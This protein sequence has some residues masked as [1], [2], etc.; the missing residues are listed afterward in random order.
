MQWGAGTP[1]LSR[2]P[3]VVIGHQH[4]PSPLE[5]ML[6]RAQYVGSPSITI[7][8][9]GTYVASHD[10]FGWGSSEKTSGITKIYRSNVR[11]ESWTQTAMLEGQFWSTVFA[12]DD[13]LY[14]IG[15]ARKSG[16]LIIRKSADA[17]ATWTEPVDEQHGLLREGRYGGT[18]NPLVEYEGRLWFSQGTRALSAPVDADLLQ[19]D[20]WTLSKGVSQDESWLDG[21]FPFWS[22]GQVTASPAEGV[23]ILPKVNQLP[24][25][26]LLHV[27]SPRDMAFN[28]YLDFAELPGAEKK[29]GVA[30][31]AVSGR[32]FA[33]TNPVLPVHKDDRWLADTPAMIRNTAALLSSSDLRHW[34]VEKIFLYSSDLYHEAFQYLNFSIDGDDLAV[35]SRTAFKLGGHKPPRGH[36]SNLMTFHRIADFRSAKPEFVL[37]IDP[38]GERVLRYENTQFQRAPLGP[39][40]LGTQPVD[41]VGLAQGEDGSVYIAEQS[42]RV[43]RFDAAGNYSDTAQNAGLNYTSSLA[44]RPPPPGERTWTG[45]DSNTWTEPTNWFY[46]GRPDTAAELAIFGSA[47]MS[48]TT[49]LLET[50]Y[51]IGGI[52]FLNTESYTVAG[53]GEVVLGDADTAGILECLRGQ[54][55]INATV[56]L[57]S[58]TTLKVEADTAIDFGGRLALAG[59]TL[60]CTGSGTLTLQGT[61]S[62]AGGTLILH[63]GDAPVVLAASA[64]L[65]LDGTLELRLPEGYYAADGDRFDLFQLGEPVNQKFEH[66]A[67]P[68]LPRGRAWDTSALYTSGVVRVVSG[69]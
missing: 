42:G 37:E 14:I 5:R 6:G 32:Y 23:V 59:H 57:G 46:W 41:P 39:F 20:S 56:S 68:D 67:L 10:L 7:L 3:G 16:N 65:V 66:I 17:G 25:T 21:R 49:V 29:F 22:E 8:P 51:R 1:D 24:Y 63:G 58:D 48:D 69:R 33:L 45:A 11:G 31:D 43:L 19:A 62:M 30:Y 18:P 52:R 9:D 4:A 35:V 47:A 12:H 26:A 28:P 15:Y 53:K 27:E 55:T 54:H 44:V 34:E 60:D 61:F 2:A 38:A 13:G 64:D 50:L 36:D 40:A